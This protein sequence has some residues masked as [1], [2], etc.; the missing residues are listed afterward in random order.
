MAAEVAPILSKMHYNG[1]L[2]YL[3]DLRCQLDIST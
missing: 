2:R 3:L 1:G